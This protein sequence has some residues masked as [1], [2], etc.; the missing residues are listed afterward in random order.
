MKT[1][2]IV[3]ARMTSSRLPGKVL[4]DLG[5]HPMLAQQLRR[6][7]RCRRTD[8]IVVATTVND[9]D[10]PVVALAN[11]EHVRWFRGSEHDVLSRYIGAAQE[12]QADVVVRITADCPLVDPD[13][14]D[15]VIEEL[16]SCAQE[17]DYASNVVDRTFP[18]GLDVEVLFFD[19]LECIGRLSQSHSAREH[20]T[21]YLRS[22]RPD[23]FLVRSITDAE[24]N[25]DL[26]WVVDSTEDITMIRL[27][28]EGLDLGNQVVP[29][30]DML[31]FVRSHPEIAQIN[32][33]VRQKEFTDL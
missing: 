32:V 22:E 21:L 26:R 8:E 27:F 10:D 14:T 25:S 23:L 7:K 29:Y 20:V 18:R 12:S 15:R 6:L 5:G 19:T 13:L 24:N 30:R 17:C 3:Q 11:V 31:T 33:H 2:T 9:A 4:M 28:Y 16:L 1:V